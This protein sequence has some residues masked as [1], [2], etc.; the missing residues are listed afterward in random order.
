[1]KQQLDEVV[2]D[3]FLIGGGN[4]NMFSFHPENWGNDPILT[5]IFQMG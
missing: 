1:V 3:M 2:G 4:S 5:H